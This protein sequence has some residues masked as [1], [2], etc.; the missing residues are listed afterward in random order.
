M[1]KSARLGTV[2]LVALRELALGR[3]QGALE[4]L[5]VAPP[6]LYRAR[7]GEV[8][9]LHTDLGSQYPQLAMDG[10]MVYLLSRTRA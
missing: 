4:L 2:L 10:D 8:L 5:R 7:E 3:V 1:A 9:R 6:A